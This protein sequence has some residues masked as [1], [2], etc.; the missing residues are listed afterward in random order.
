MGIDQVIGYIAAT[1]TTLSF[2][3]QV[4][5][6]WRTRDTSSLSLSMYATFTTGVFLWF[7]YGLL[8]H[9]WIV[10]LANF[11]TLLFAT[12]I[13]CFKIYQTYRDRK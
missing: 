7:V 3:P 4:I 1:L 6:T 12:S 2:L 5:L 9:D 13:L 10:T 11:V 8:R